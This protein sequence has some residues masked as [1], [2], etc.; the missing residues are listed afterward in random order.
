MIVN[1]FKNSVGKYDVLIA[2]KEGKRTN[3][4][5]YRYLGVKRLSDDIFLAECYLKRAEVKIL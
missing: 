2:C 4:T 1:N 5:S 3:E